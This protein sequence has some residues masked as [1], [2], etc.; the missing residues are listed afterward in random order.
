[1]PEIDRYDVGTNLCQNPI[2]SIEQTP[3]RLPHPWA[4]IENNQDALALGRLLHNNV[5]NTVQEELQSDGVHFRWPCC[6]LPSISRSLT[7][8]GKR[9]VDETFSLGRSGTEGVLINLGGVSVG[10]I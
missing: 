6:T 2:M 1:M 7:V 5:D 3:L 9:L 10:L 4:A 8:P